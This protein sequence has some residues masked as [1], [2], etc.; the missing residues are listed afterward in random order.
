MYRQTFL[1]SRYAPPTCVLLTALILS[2][3]ILSAKTTDV[4]QPRPFDSVLSRVVATLISTQH[5]TKKPLNDQVS[6]QLF[7]EFFTTLDREKRFFLASD[8]EEFTSYRKML[9][10]QVYAG[11]LDFAFKV[12]ER[13]VE[14]VRERVDY[15]RKRL[16]KPFDFSIEE[17]IALDRSEVAWCE[18]TEELDEVWRKLL[19]NRVLV[20]TLMAESAEEEEGSK[21]PEGGDEDGAEKKPSPFTQ[22]SPTE[23][24]L[25]SQ[26]RYL[27]YIEENESIDVVEM[28]LSSLT[29]VYDPHSTYMA[30]M[31][32]EDFDINMKLSLEGIGAVLST[33]DGYVKVVDIIE[34]GP[35]ERDNRLKPGD[36]IIGVAQE[37]GEGTDVVDMPLRKVV[38]LI[39]GEKGS[40]V[41]L[42]V[43]EAGK[44]LG[45]VPSTIDIVRD[46]VKLTEK[47]AKSETK[48]VTL[49]NGTEG[50][51][52]KQ[53]RE[54]EVMVVKLPSF[55]SD[56]AAKRRKEKDFRS[57]ARDVRKLLEEGVEND[58][59]GVIL[60]LRSNG[61]GSLDEAIDLAGLFFSEGPVVQVKG[62]GRRREVHSDKDDVTVYGGPLVIL[63]NR[64]SASAS[65][66]VAAA[67]QDHHRGVI[68]GDASTHGKG[69]VQTVYDLQR[70]FAKDPVFRDQETGSLKFTIAKF[71]RVNGE[72]TQKRGVIPDVIFPAYTD[73]MEIGEATLNHALRWD[74][75]D[76]LE[77][78]Y[79][80]DVTPYLPVL[81]TRVKARVAE[82]PAFAKHEDA[83]AKYAKLRNRKST[84]LNI[85]ERRRLQEEEEKWIE[86]IRNQTFREDDDHKKDGTAEDGEDD[87]KKAKAPDLV[88]E[89]ALRVL[90]DLIW[91]Q[92]GDLVAE[93]KPKVPTTENSV[94]EGVEEE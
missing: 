62:S 66:I 10:N 91:L 37:G 23:R 45:S 92:E 60:D 77:R 26:E 69:T 94:G 90:A 71:Y 73:H 22:K 83:V 15:A 5:Y 16:D 78:K 39:R 8:V 6:Q 68:I 4:P 76:P 21:A 61:G 85:D 52:A 20:F 64:M 7:D 54:A 30:P 2:S 33:E 19:K 82:N 46:K 17:E 67:I 42:S 9:D 75:I 57:S 80:I 24:V 88:L 25:S 72:S 29:R 18:T 87:G 43:I 53:A 13:F 41:Y 32:E 28:F 74:E 55:Y 63:V 59:S 44:A 11:E 35:A 51:I 38:R 1:R 79:D 58:V 70:L 36:R 93:P 3:G 48:M 86:E 34:G 31:T 27:S 14:R 84:T 81:T 47:G 65:E 50:G 12:Y 56:F 89:E 40:T 49:P